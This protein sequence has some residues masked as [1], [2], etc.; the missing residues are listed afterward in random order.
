M[1]VDSGSSLWT[2]I[3]TRSP[4]VDLDRRAGHAAVVPPDVEPLVGQELALHVLGVEVELL[5]PVLHLP[6]QLRHVGGL[7]RDGRVAV[8]P[9]AGDELAPVVHPAV[10]G[11]FV[12]PGR[13]LL[14]RGR[15]G[16]E[17]AGEPRAAEEKIPTVRFRAHGIPLVGIAPASRCPWFLN[18]TRRPTATRQFASVRDFLPGLVAP[19]AGTTP[20]RPFGLWRDRRASGLASGPQPLPTSPSDFV[21]LSGSGSN[22]AT[23][24]G[25]QKAYRRP[26][27]VRSA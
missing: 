17:S 22:A 2:T 23:H 19:R 7:D 6:L 25:Q 15:A 9:P 11:V 3:R 24:P 5:H 16:E 13:L 21:Y 20:P 26:P 8:L 27:C 10:A 14:R 1:M 18:S 12:F 4:S